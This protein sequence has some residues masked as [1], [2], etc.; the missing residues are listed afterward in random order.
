MID[1]AAVNFWLPFSRDGQID[2]QIV[3]SPVKGS[4][5]EPECAY[6]EVY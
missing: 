6:A 1:S 2:Q 4:K 3:N 5:I